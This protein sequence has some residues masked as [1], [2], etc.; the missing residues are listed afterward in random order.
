MKSLLND[1]FVEAIRVADADVVLG[2]FLPKDQ[3]GKVTVIGAGKG[4]A[5]MARAFEEAWDGEVSGMVITRYGHAVPTKYVEVVEA[6]HPVPDKAGQD[7]AARMM[8]MVE[9]L[10]E[11]DLVVALISGGGSALLTLPVE[12]I[13]LEEKQ[14]V[15]KALL[16]SGAT[17]EEIN[18]VRKHLSAIKGGRLAKACYPAKV[19]TLSISDVPGDD[20]SVIASG[21]TVADPTTVADA[22]TIL[23]RYRIEGYSDHLSESI[24]P[25]DSCWAKTDYKLIATPQISLQAVA[26]MAKAKGIP[27]MILSDRIEGEAR[28]VAK[29]HAAIVRQIQDWGQPIQPPCLLLSGGEVTVTIKNPDGRG[30]PNGE[31]VLSL[32]DQLRDVDNVY[33]LAADTDGID[34]SE[35]NAGA[36][37]DPTSITRMKERG[38]N[39]HAALDDN[40]SYDFFEAM[41]DLFKPGPT[42]TNVNDLRMIYIGE[43]K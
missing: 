13:T 26:D 27:A 15:N 32:M 12:S 1:L 14:S 8:E 24:K 22:R 40:L 11:D 19:L 35:D 28:E 23:E 29:V 6:S 33:A 7:A 25:D 18:C 31:F 39:L 10:G 4:A 34:G 36:W 5:K 41:G 9:G 21:P 17:I 38:L 3:S 2:G 43:K 20:E 37:F 30:G 16:H 42:H